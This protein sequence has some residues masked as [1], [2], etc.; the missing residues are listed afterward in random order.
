VLADPVDEKPGST[1]R[2]RR[3][4][5]Q[6]PL[7]SDFRLKCPSAKQKGAWLTDILGLQEK[8]MSEDRLSRSSAARQQL[9]NMGS[10][11]WQQIMKG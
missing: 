11:E 4:S 9:P 6:K 10:T 1:I 7:N 5:V 8:L 3:M 2:S